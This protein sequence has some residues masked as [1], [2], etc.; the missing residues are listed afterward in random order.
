[1][2]AGTSSPLRNV[3][4]GTRNRLLRTAGEQ[5]TGIAGHLCTACI[6]GSTM[7]WVRLPL[8]DAQH[9]EH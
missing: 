5:E 2:P 6:V 1:M 9:S 7:E 8:F 4:F 3:V